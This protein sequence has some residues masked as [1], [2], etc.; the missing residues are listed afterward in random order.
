MVDPPLPTGQRLRAGAVLQHYEIIRAIGRAQNIYLD[1]EN[2]SQE[3]LDEIKS[4]FE[5]LA[6]K[7]RARQMNAQIDL[8]K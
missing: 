6:A 1:L 7:A 2:R 4:Q 8:H 5:A 3:E